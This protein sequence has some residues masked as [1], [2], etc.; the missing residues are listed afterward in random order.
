MNRN[1]PNAEER[2]VRPP[3]GSSD[4]STLGRSLSSPLTAA[5]HIPE[6]LCP[7]GVIATA[8]ANACDGVIQPRVCRGRVLSERAILSSSRCVHCERSVDLGRYWR[9]SPL[10]FSLLPRCQGLL[11]L[12]K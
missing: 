3:V 1:T 9:S 10:V 6:R 7:Q 2:R 12:T 11:G 4:P 5:V 8:L